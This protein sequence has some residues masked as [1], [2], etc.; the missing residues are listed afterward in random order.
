MGRFI[1]YKKCRHSLCYDN[2]SLSVLS[3]TTSNSIC[4]LLKKMGDGLVKE[5]F[6][7]LFFGC[8]VAFMKRGIFI[9]PHSPINLMNF[10][11]PM[12]GYFLLK[13][14]LIR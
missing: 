1:D 5:F 10:S 9:F 14:L 13:T 8:S 3:I 12:V 2:Y 7:W 6:H 4:I 11:L